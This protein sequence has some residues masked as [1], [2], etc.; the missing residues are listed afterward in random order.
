M[1]LLSFDNFKKMQAIVENEEMLQ[2]SL[3][4][5]MDLWEAEQ[6]LNE[7]F[8]SSILQ[9]LI[10][11][12]TGQGKWR[13]N[14]QK[15]LYKKY[16]IAIGDIQDTDFTVLTDPEAF[17][18]RPYKDDD[19]YIGFCVNDN[20]EVMKRV[21]KRTS[22]APLLI[23]IVMGGR[24]LFYGFAKEKGYRQGGDDKYG[25]LADRWGQSTYF[26][27]KYN[28]IKP[29]NAK[30]IQEFTTKVYVIN[31]ADLQAKYSVSAKQSER[32]AARRGAAALIDNKTIKSQNIERYKK[33]LSEK[34]GPGDILA[35]FQRLFE[36]TSTAV[37]DWAKSV[38]LE[39]IEVV[40]NYGEFQYGGHWRNTPGYVLH[41]IYD[42]FGKY[43]YDYVEFA[44]YEA[45]IERMAS[46]IEN[47]KTEE[48]EDMTE[49][50]KQRYASNIEYY[51]GALKQMAVKFVEYKHEF[52]KREKE[53]DA[54]IAYMNGLLTDEGK[55]KLE[56]H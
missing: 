46:C 23:S 8:S 19:N 50:L 10:D 17:F 14:F 53:V 56:L 27:L 4:E 16:R 52:D 26:G 33:I 18:K 54:G 36:K 22:G 28:D 37:T 7:G 32:A 49:E 40:K 9:Q 24:G 51:E 31:I 43:M 20:P 11:G 44:R 42:L 2:G 55:A 38:K 3:A 25:A 35:Q 21:E 1:K 6:L 29:T 34:V 41:A 12:D 13:N 5:K 39:D 45:R 47:G 15:D 48:G 30:W